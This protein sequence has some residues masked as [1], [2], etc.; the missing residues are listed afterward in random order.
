[1]NEEK[2]PEAPPRKPT[3]V[4]KLRIVG[5][6]A[7]EVVQFGARRIQTV[8]LAERKAAPGVDT[9]TIRAAE[10]L[11]YPSAAAAN[12]VYVSATKDTPAFVIPIANCAHIEVVE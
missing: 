1:M 6:R 11:W 8:A 2:K 10:L 7:A 12:G 3:D 9:T 5:L 4:A